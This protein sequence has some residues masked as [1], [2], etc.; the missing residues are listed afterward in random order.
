MQLTPEVL[1]QQA[2]DLGQACRPMGLMALNRIDAAGRLQ[3]VQLSTNRQNVFD[4]PITGQLLAHR[5]NLAEMNA[6]SQGSDH[7]ALH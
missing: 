2:I 6:E 1:W 3:R 7:S 5:R 4:L